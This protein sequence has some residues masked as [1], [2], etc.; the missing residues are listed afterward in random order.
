MPENVVRL[1]CPNL[2][3]RAILAV[4]GEARGRLVRCK[5]CGAN[6]KIPDKGGGEPAKPDVSAPA[7]KPAA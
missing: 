6:I 3:C 2:R 7:Q 5:N 4:P 1:M